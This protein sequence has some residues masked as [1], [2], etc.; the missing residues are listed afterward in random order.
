MLAH[1][2]QGC[3]YKMPTNDV[4]ATAPN[5]NNPIVTREKSQGVIPGMK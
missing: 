4:I 3:L 1:L 2:L 5:T